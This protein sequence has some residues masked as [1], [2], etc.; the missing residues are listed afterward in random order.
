MF[1]R[2]VAAALAISLSACTALPP[3]PGTG[4]S[5]G[6]GA[7]GSGT[8]G[9]GGNAGIG[10]SGGADPCA[11]VI[12]DPD[13]ETIESD[14]SVKGDGEVTAFLCSGGLCELEDSMDSWAFTL[15]PNCGGTY[16][17][18]LTWNNNLDDDLDLALFDSNGEVDRR[19]NRTPEGTKPGSLLTEEITKELQS[20]EA[21]VVQ[22][23]AIN[24]S[25]NR[26]YR[27]KVLLVD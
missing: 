13:D 14:D 24:T 6:D 27:L 4:G 2:V 7:S 26:S 9:I 12:P 16:Q 25:G 21:Y 20:E 23:I 8:G 18:L 15:V 5:G 3:V 10:G 17:I 11:L 22:V 1:R 19:E